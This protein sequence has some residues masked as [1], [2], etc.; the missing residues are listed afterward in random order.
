MVSP[1]LRE[2]FATHD[3]QELL[4]PLSEVEVEAIKKRLKAH[5]II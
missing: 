4:H 2:I 5:G 1:V 3:S